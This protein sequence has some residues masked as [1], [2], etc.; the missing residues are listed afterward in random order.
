M[1]QRAKQ[2]QCAQKLGEAACRIIEIMRGGRGGERDENERFDREME[3]GQRKGMIEGREEDGDCDENDN[4]NG[5]YEIVRSNLD[6]NRIYLTF[7]FCNTVS[8]YLVIY[9]VMIYNVMSSHVISYISI[10]TCHIM[11]VV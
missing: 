7:L 2:N 4:V 11:S 9:Y 6:G 8:F 1:V 3:K 5:A 10:F